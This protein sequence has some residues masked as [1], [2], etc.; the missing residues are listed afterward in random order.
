M[1]VLHVIP[2]YE[3][4]W[5]FGGTVTATTNLCRTMARQGLDITVYTTDADG[6]G[7]HLDV[8]LN[9]PLDLGG[10]KV[11]YFYCDLGLK[12][13]FY[14]SMLSKRIK[15][16]VKDFDL[17]HVSAIWQWIQVNVN[18]ACK[19]SQIPYIV[20]PNGSFI[21]YAWKQNILKKRPYWYLV[22]RK[23]IEDSAAIHFTT[24]VE[25]EDSLFTLRPLKPIPTFVVPNGIG[26]KKGARTQDMREVLNIPEDKFLMLFLGRI[27]RI[28]GIE[29]ILE[30]LA[31]IRDWEVYLLIVGPQEDREYY[32]YLRALS[33]ELNVD[34]NI[35][36]HE[37]VNGNEVSNFYD[38]SNLYVLPSYS[39]NFAMTVVEA[40][41][42]GLPVLISKNVGIWREVQADGAGFV[43]GQDVQEI[44]NIL[45]RISKDRQSVLQLSQNAR[46][47][48]EN[49][50][51]IN[52]VSSL[53]IK[54][55]ED[56]LTGR[57]SPELQWL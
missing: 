13:A 30:A 17:V 51:E 4:A 36:W 52:K 56:V 18:R 6:K 28:K 16:T 23:T 27:H 50:Y 54:A 7:G 33:R 34:N 10:V 47:S 35:V 1:K 39:E 12:K 38:C 5:A 3:P 20:S 46:K 55:Y 19:N 49:R 53:M 37:A 45:R 31:L 44:A 26:L 2:S 8:T 15:E 32:N 11:C 25:R 41:A 24:E 42:C 48:A 9:E 57:R 40:M 22:G 43:A 21:R 29:Y 14:S